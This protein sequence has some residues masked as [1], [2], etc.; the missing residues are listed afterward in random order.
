MFFLLHINEWGQLLMIFLK[1]E[2]RSDSWFRLFSFFFKMNKQELLQSHWTLTYFWIEFG[3]IV[4]SKNTT[5][6]SVFVVPKGPF[7]RCHKHRERL[8]R[9]A[10]ISSFTGAL[11]WHLS[12]VFPFITSVSKGQAPAAGPSEVLEPPTETSVTQKHMG[13]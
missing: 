1:G 9:E 8:S 13:Q 10:F 11:M 5:K 12:L 7:L 2:N 6:A 4:E 3:F